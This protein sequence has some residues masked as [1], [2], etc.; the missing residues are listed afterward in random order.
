[1]DERQKKCHPDSKQRKTFRPIHRKFGVLFVRLYWKV[2]KLQVGS[3]QEWRTSSFKQEI[4]RAFF[5]VQ[6]T[7]NRTE[8][9]QNHRCSNHLHLKYHVKVDDMFTNGFSLLYMVDDAIQF[10]ATW[11]LLYQSSQNIWS[12]I[13]K[14]LLSVYPCRFAY[15]VFEKITSVYFA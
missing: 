8:Q 14:M 6:Q 12:R 7:M 3:S 15:L 4:D 1:M 9:I 11:L 5:N 10:R 13:P 2:V